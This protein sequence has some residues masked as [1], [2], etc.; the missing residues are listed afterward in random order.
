MWLARLSEVS[1][2]GSN[3]IGQINWHFWTEVANNLP[4]GQ[5]A[6]CR[7]NWSMTLRWQIYIH[8]FIKTGFKGIP[9]LKTN[10]LLEEGINIII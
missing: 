7:A 6:S 8:T 4:E 1:G 5:S 10:F 2:A 9:K 3:M